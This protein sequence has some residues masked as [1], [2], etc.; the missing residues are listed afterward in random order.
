[1]KITGPINLRKNKLSSYQSY[2]G[3]NVIP[4]PQRH[5][6]LPPA[7]SKMPPLYIHTCSLHSD[8]IRLTHK[9]HPITSLA[10]GG[11]F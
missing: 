9:P 4:S 5:T 1:M 3:F 7:A 11:Q 6:A 8:D 2:L 10:I